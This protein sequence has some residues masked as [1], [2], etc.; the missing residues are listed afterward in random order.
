MRREDLKA[1]LQSIGLKV[2]GDK[3]KVKDVKAAL[4]VASY[5]EALPHEDLT[6]LFGQFP[7]LEDQ[8][9]VTEEDGEK[10]A[11]L[12]PEVSKDLERTYKLFTDQTHGEKRLAEAMDRVKRYAEKVLKA[13][14]PDV[15]F[16]LETD[17]RF[18]DSYVGSDAGAMYLTLWLKDD[19][20][21]VESGALYFSGV[22]EGISDT[23][24]S[25]EWAAWLMADDSPF[26]SSDFIEAY[27]FD[28]FSSAMEQFSHD[29]DGTEFED[30]VL[31][32]AEKLVKS[33]EN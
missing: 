29:L 6:E 27:A 25:Y 30:E 13:K 16:E 7:D 2:V 20:E 19:S 15:K 8:V 22:Y 10:Y 24:E 18:T 12:K 4:V 28:T 1:Q 32:A 23:V 26:H 3:V 33:S 14:Y 11:K 31:K 17:Y 5:S 9:V 21:E